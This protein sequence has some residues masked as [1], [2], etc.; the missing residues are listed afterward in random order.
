MG[1]DVVTLAEAEALGL[2]AVVLE[3]FAEFAPRLLAALAILVIGWILAR[4]L[5]RI[6]G[7]LL[8][9]RAIDPT[10]TPV[11]RAVVR[12]GVL[13]VTFVAVLGQLGIKTASILAVLGAAG[14]AIGL[15]LQGTLSNIAAGM[16]LLWLRPFRVGDYIDNGSIAGTVNEIGLFATEMTTFDGIYRFVPNSELWNRQV[17][18]YTRNG[19]RWLV[20]DYGISYDDDVEQA[21]RTLLALVEGDERTL[22]EPAPQAIVTSLADSAVVVTL[23]VWV[24]TPDYWNVR[25]ELIERGKAALEAAGCTI[26]FPQRTVHVERGAAIAA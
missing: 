26:P 12:Y 6:V 15:A 3:W 25:F 9:R 17:Q 10:I 18:N 8:D 22:D 5:A 13:I 19:K 20:L 11:V 21:K 23:R 24:R 16:M 7:H 4:W 14:L 2:A 1:D